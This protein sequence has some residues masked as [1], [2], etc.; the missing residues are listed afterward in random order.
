MSLNMNL[1]SPGSFVKHINRPDV[2]LWVVIGNMSPCAHLLKSIPVDGK[3]EIIRGDGPN[4]VR[5]DSETTSV[6][7]HYINEDVYD[8]AI[9]MMLKGNY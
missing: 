5:L 1:Y 9:K 4:L 3:Y 2:P 7:F 8:E 6:G